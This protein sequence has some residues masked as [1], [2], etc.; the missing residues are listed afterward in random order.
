MGIDFGKERWLHVKETSRRWW[1]GELDR[2]IIVYRAEDGDP[3][4]PEP[5]TPYHFFMG[6][7]DF[8][9][10]ADAI[11]DRWH[12][13]TSKQRCYGDGYPMVWLNF[14]PGIV[15]A[16]LGAKVTP[17]QYTT[18]FHPAKDVPVA[19]LHFEYDADNP[20]WRRVQDVARAMVNRFEGTVQIGTS[21]LGGA[22]DL[23]STFRPAERLLLD[24]IDHPEDVKRCIWELHELWHRYYTE[25][26]AILQ[27]SNPGYSAWDGTFCPETYYMLQCDFCY[28]IGPDMFDEF[29][30]PELEATFQRLT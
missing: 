4:R 24:L 5:R 11:A 3:G 1:A 27:P 9:I 19:E 25:L 18:W 23:L 26:N 14:G 6:N 16:F 22:V 20:W 8:S 13:E 28:M 21:D 2:P 15:A 29:I 10:S 12:W 30:R 17:A 7:Y